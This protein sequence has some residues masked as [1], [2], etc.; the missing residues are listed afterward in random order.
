[1]EISMKRRNS[2][3][4]SSII[5]AV[6]LIAGLT[7]SN[8][9]SLHTKAAQDQ[10]PTSGVDAAVDAPDQNPSEDPNRLARLQQKI[11]TLQANLKQD[12]LVRLI[13]GLRGEFSEEDSKTGR[14][15]I[16]VRREKIG[17]AQD[18]LLNKLFVRNLGSIKKFRSIPFLV[19]ELDASGLAQ[20]RASE[21]VESITEDT[22]DAPSLAESTVVIGAPVAWNLGFTGAG[23][24]VAI[25]DTG[26]D[27]DHS[28]LAGKIVSE[29]CFST[30]SAADN[31]TSICPGGAASSTAAGSADNLGSGV[32]GF[33]HGTHVAGIAAGRNQTLSGVARDASI[34][35]I[36]VFS[37]FNDQADC[38]TAPAPCLRSF[39][40]DQIEGLE[41]VQDLSD[42]F[43]I[44]AVN[45]SLG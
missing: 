42:N 44:A 27:N 14:T 16:V 7:V 23:Q 41:R 32:S 34:I 18:S 2:Q 20:L 8:I 15:G 28:F 29:A 5:I 6:V 9:S 11:D 31:T 13:V 30:T 45:L 3:Y 12:G 36:K 37:R 24:T 26:V 10:R 38:G 4:K 21:E 25:L 33:D 39:R 22:H 43:N 17:H 1:M 35:A 40:S 19:V